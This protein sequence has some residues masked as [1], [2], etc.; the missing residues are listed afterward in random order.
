[1]MALPPKS[2]TKAQCRAAIGEASKQIIELCEKTQKPLILEDLDFQKKKAQ[3]R[4][5]H[6]SYA[7]MLSSFAYQSILS[8]LKS[9]GASKG[10]E[11]YSVSPAF[12][13]FI[14][15]KLQTCGRL[16]PASLRLHSRQLYSSCPLAPG[17]G[18]RQNPL[19]ISKPYF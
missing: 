11:V 17:F 7:R 9:R 12:I 8:H 4:E 6:N 15:I 19:R 16:L 18:S 2:A 3:L 5:K 13:P 14:K 10:I 1:M